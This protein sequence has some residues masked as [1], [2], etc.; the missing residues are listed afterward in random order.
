MG[1]NVV[2][3]ALDKKYVDDSLIGLGALRGKPCTIKSSEH[4][5][6]V[7]TVIF[8]W[9]AL[10]DDGITEV[11]QETEIQVL[12]GTPIF[13]WESGNTY[14]YGDLVIYASAFYRCIRENSDIVF[15][16]TKWNE[17]GSPDGNYDL[18]QNASLLPP[19]FTSADR[20]MYYAINDY[21]N[22][23]GILYRSG[24]YL[25][26]GGKWIRTQPPVL[27][28]FSEL[29]EYEAD[30]ITIRNIIL[31]FDGKRVITEKDLSYEIVDNY[32]SIDLTVEHDVMYFV[33]NATINVL[34]NVEHY[35]G[36]YYYNSLNKTLEYIHERDYKDIDFS[37]E[38][39][40]IKEG[41]I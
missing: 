10:E 29:I 16:D 3:Y 22:D 4:K 41:K 40:D 20:K 26:D 11:K 21:I 13:V 39:K 15:D 18:V 25:W 14:H 9:V 27:D 28:R 2:N 33:K 5:D 19:R 23:S 8:E 30:G 32:S 37:T 6:G 38:Y 17:I 7:T 31:F 12:D 35:S 1:F 34:G 24:Y 36:E